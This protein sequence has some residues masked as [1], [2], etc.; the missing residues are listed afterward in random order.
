[1]QRHVDVTGSGVDARLID[2]DIDWR[3][4]TIGR[5]EQAIGSRAGASLSIS[6]ESA[7]ELHAR[8]GTFLKNRAKEQAVP[9]PPVEDP[10]DV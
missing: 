9:A 4:G 5:L 8:L 7:V 3:E 10:S 2:I 1:M 6:E